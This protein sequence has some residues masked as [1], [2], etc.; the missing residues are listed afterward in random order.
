MDNLDSLGLIVTIIL[1][2]NG[3]ATLIARRKKQ[4]EPRSPETDA[5]STETLPEDAYNTR[6]DS[7]TPVNKDPLQQLEEALQELGGLNASEDRTTAD[8]RIEAPPPPEPVPAAAKPP[9]EY[10]PY[11]G[12]QV[13]EPETVRRPV[14]K[15]SVMA[16]ENEQR[17]AAADLGHGEET[18]EFDLRQAVIWN[19]LLR[20]PLSRRCRNR[21]I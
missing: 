9:S 18:G 1:V 5:V 10:A 20:P 6:E 11:L 2:L 15:V 4:G 12:E 13:S 21:V 8:I 17:Q 3:I 7:E 16:A 14:S 19:E